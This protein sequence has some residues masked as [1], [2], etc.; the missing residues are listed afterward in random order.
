MDCLK[1]MDDVAYVRSDAAKRGWAM[2]AARMGGDFPKRGDYVW[3]EQVALLEYERRETGGLDS[4]T[5][6]RPGDIIQ[7]RNVRLAGRGPGGGTY[8]MTAD[9]HTAVVA[10]VDPAGGE[11]TCYHQNWG[12][13]IVKQDRMQLKDM[14]SGWMRIYR[15]VAAE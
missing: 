10:S 3:G 1:K 11:L 14:Q 7:F 8:G 5:K 4:L 15:P 6:V 12:R 13:M 9:H 2:S